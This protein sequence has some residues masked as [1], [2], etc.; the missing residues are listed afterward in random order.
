M[1]FPGEQ[2]R[3]SLEFGEF[4][5]DRSRRLLLRDGQ[6]V[7]LPGKAFDVLS[8]LLERR[9]E[10]VTKEELFRTVWSGTVVEEGNL[11]QTIFVLRKALGDSEGQALILNI[12][13]RGYRFG[14]TVS[15]AGGAAAPSCEQTTK[16]QPQ[17]PRP[18]WWTGVGLAAAVAAVVAVFQAGVFRKDAEL[19]TPARFTVEPPA[20]VVFREGR[21]SPDGHWLAFIGTD[22]SWRKQLWVRPLDSLA[23]T[24]LARAEGTPIWSPNSRY[25]AFA[26]EG[27]LKKISISGGVPQVICKAPLVIGGSWNR[28]GKIIF[29]GETSRSAPEIDIV[30]A[31][32]G[33]ASPLTTVDSKRG[34][35]QHVF[36]VFLPDGKHFLYTIQGSRPEFRGIFISSLDAPDRSVRL[37]PEVSNAEYASGYLLYARGGSLMAQPFAP[38][39]LRVTGEAVTL[40]DKIASRASVPGGSFSA[41]SGGMLVVSTPVFGNQLTWFNRQGRRTATI[42]EPSFYMAPQIAPDEKSIVV[43]KVDPDSFSPRVWW[44]PIEG[45]PSRFTFTPSQ[46]PLWLPDGES[47]AYATRD[48]A[49]H[50]KP[51]AATADQKLLLRAGTM[52]SDGR[53][54]C[55]FSRDGRALVYTELGPKTGYDL[56]RLPANGVPEILLNSESNEMCGAISAD[57]RWIAYSSDE[58]GR[59]EIYVRS[60]P[61]RGA[62]T[63][64]M[65]QVSNNGGA[66]PVWRRDGREVFFLD[67]ERNLIA[68]RVSAGSGL[69]FGTPEVLFPTRIHTPDARFDVSADGNRF[70]IPA[71]TSGSGMPATVT[72]NW[73]ATLNAR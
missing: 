71:E 72:I 9:G 35:S 68:V 31:S 8:V 16:T 20:G 6:V 60:L 32:G 22:A 23:A 51:V 13:R 33:E 1:N 48:T 49:I 39:K 64:R 46:Y 54:P 66:W 29:G 25:L 14:G 62:A 73:T 28:D 63:G 65:W 44:I 47:I 7:P 26:D 3:E 57:G 37:N 61:E 41:A 30:A 12:P 40:M 5:L 18:A 42:G 55:G 36:P 43:E 17:I 24:P 56:W 27:L 45:A 10:T 58:S 50:V 38:S 15:T 59:P 67:N 2:D 53:I 69:R 52:P 70:D 34:E 21:I 11:T 19:R 4:R